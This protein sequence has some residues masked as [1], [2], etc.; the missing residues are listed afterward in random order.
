M[1]KITLLLVLFITIISFA[2]NETEA[3]KILNEVSAKMKNYDTLYVEFSS[4]LDND[5]Q[6]VHQI[7]KGNVSLKGDLFLVNLLGITTIFDGK[8]VYSINS[9]DEE[10]NISEKDEDTFTP[11][12]FFSFYEEGY[13]FEMAETTSKNGQ[14]LQFIKLLPIDNE[15]EF[16]YVLLGIDS[17]TM[18]IKTIIQK[19]KNGTD[20]TLTI[21]NFKTNLELSS[22]LFTFNKSK[23]EEKGY[24][25]NEL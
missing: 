6:D 11:A 24:I 14:K 1:K 5:E 9:E 8:Q 23:Y 2:Q 4:S 22:K 25:I 7:T 20:Y 15:S 10:V 12:Q 17:N 18:H 13:T 21:S 19:G 3:K 16:N